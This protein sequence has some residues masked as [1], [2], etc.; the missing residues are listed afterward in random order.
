MQIAGIIS[1]IL[2]LLQTILFTEDSTGQGVYAHA[3]LVP[4]CDKANF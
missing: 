1:H 4:R 2:L 3:S